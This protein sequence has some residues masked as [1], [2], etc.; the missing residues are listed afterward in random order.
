MSEGTRYVLRTAGG[1]AIIAN[2]DLLPTGYLDAADNWQPVGF[3]EQ[4]AASLDAEGLEA[5][6]LVAVSVPARPVGVQVL[7]LDVVAEGDVP[8]LIWRTEQ[9]TEVEVANL[10]A[11][12]IA[13]VKAEASRRILARFPT[14][15]QANMNMRATELVDIRLGRELTTEETAERDAL[16]GAA[17]WIKAVRTA[18]DD[19]EA[20]LPDDAEGLSAFSAAAADGW[21]A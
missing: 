15:K 9:L 18:S 3:V 10:Y 5:R 4:W 12:R 16:L 13:D 11:G 21:P 6:G 8:A 14:W 19:I 17:A 20:A 7:A 1:W 2:G